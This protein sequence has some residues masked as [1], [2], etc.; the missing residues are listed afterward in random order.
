MVCQRFVSG[1]FRDLP[2]EGGFDSLDLDRVGAGGLRGE[3]GE[4]EEEVNDPNHVRSSIVPF[5][6]CGDL[7]GYV[8]PAGIDFFD[9]DKSYPLEPTTMTSTQEDATLEMERR[10]RDFS[11]DPTPPPSSSEGYIEPIAPPI[12]PPYQTSMAKAKEA[13]A[14][15]AFTTPG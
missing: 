4:E 3:K 8:P 12:R 5:V 10:I 15:R 6:A 9:S 11:L 14:K 7:S 1:V 13:R 2:L